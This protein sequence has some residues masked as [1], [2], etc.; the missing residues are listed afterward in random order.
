MAE[1]PQM[2]QMPQMPYMGQIPIIC[3]PFIMSQ[4]CPMLYNQGAAGMNQM[5]PNSSAVSPYMNNPMMGMQY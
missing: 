2:P 4:H 5:M 1:V 3:C